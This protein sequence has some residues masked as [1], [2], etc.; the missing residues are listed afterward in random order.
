[1]ATLLNF[2][3]RNQTR[4]AGPV[5]HGAKADEKPSTCCLNRLLRT[6]GCFVE[7]RQD[8]LLRRDAV[9]GMRNHTQ[10]RTRNRPEHLDSMLRRDDV[11]VADDDEGRRLDA[12]HLL[13]REAW[14]H[15]P[16]ALQASKDVGPMVYAVGRQATVGVGYRQGV[17]IDGAN[18]LQVLRGVTIIAGLRPGDYELRHALRVMD[19]HVEADDSP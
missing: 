9:A 11:A 19:R 17:G 13:A 4:C 5:T 7:E 8:C 16:H 1:M 14:F 18:P 15:G 2:R 12:L 3:Q 10:L 6:S